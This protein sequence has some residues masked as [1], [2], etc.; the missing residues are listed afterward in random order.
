MVPDR[1]DV[2]LGAVAKADVVEEGEDHSRGGE[3]AGEFSEPRG[4]LV[5]HRARLT[6]DQS[7]AF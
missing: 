7:A 2:L 1:N 5:G 3:D 4:K 6:R